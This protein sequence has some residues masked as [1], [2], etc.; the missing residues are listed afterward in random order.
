MSAPRLWVGHQVWVEAL[1]SPGFPV[2]VHAGWWEC[3]GDSVVAEPDL[4]PVVWGAVSGGFDQ[5][6]VVGADEHEV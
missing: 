1:M 2:G 4:P 5:V 3:F 6:V